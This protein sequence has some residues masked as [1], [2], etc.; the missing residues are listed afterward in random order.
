MPRIAGFRANPGHDFATM[1][2]LVEGAALTDDSENPA[3]PF[4]AETGPAG[5]LAGSVRH[6]HPD[7]FVV[8]RRP[9]AFQK[10]CRR[11]LHFL[12]GGG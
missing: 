8:E 3:W 1:A 5:S 10:I 11:T 2:R 12:S 4:G 7:A 6:L 9:S